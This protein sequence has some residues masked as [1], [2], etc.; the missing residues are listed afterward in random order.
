VT[1]PPNEDAMMIAFFNASIR[2]SLDNRESLFFWYDPWLYGAHLADIASDLTV[3]VASR[4]R[5]QCYVASA[6]LNNNWTCDITG[7]LTVPVLMQFIDV[8]ERLQHIKLS[9]GLPD[10][11]S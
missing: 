4:H 5:K 10:T 8:W 1:L 6:L 2:M 11:F 9:S 3:A 7:A